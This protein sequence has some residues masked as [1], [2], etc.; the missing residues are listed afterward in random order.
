MENIGSVHVRLETNDGRKTIHLIRADVEVAG[1]TIFI[2]LHRE[3]KWPYRIE[4]MSQYPFEMVQSVSKPQVP[5]YISNRV[6][7][8]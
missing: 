5:L 8:E 4:N 7:Q 2:T 1:A 3:T 6:L